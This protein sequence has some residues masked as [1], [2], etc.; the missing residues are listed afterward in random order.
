MGMRMATS[1]GL[2]GLLAVVACQSSDVVSPDAMDPPN[3]APG[4]R[5]GLVV[6]FTTKSPLPGPVG[7]D[8]T[9]SRA[10]FRVARLR[11]IGDAGPGDT[12]TSRDQLVLDWNAGTRPAA[13]EFADAPSGLYS[14]VLIDTDGETVADSY[15]IT[16]TVRLRGESRAFRVHDLEPLKIAIDTSVAL[17]PGKRAA[18]NIQ[19]ELGAAFEDLD[20]SDVPEEDGILELSMDDSQ[21]SKFRNRLKSA[22]MAIE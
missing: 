19:L 6:P 3:D 8:I 22:F 10:L 16:G 18:V 21:L 4:N 1:A 14:K 5:P 20:F 11:V 9:V 13:I 12:R 17:D 15:D 7:R 2:A